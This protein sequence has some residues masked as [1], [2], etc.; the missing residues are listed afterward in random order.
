MEAVII[1]IYVL[2]FIIFTLIAF[3]FMQIRL[4]G[5]KIKDFWSFIKANQSLDSLYR[6]AKRY[7]KLSNQQQVMFLKEAE[8]VFSAFEKIPEILWEEEYPKY[9]DVLNAYKNI[10]LL[11]WESN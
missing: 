11:R 8:E 7:E 6:F 1:V 2:I 10:K 5:M 4:A 3:A 9:I